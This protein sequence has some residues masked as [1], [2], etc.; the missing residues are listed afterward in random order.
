MSWCVWLCVSFEFVC[1][2]VY[3]YI[4]TIGELRTTC[5]CLVTSVVQADSKQTNKQ[6]K[7]NKHANN[8]TSSLDK[9]QETNKQTNYLHSKKQTNQRT[10]YINRN[11]RCNK[12][13]NIFYTS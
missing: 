2:S 3:I 12:Q 5:V 7:K 6:H 1:F 8:I 13:V 10:N 4:H 11:K 9:S